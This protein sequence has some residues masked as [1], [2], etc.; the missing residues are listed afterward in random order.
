M[1]NVYCIGN[2]VTKIN[3]ASLYSAKLKWVKVVNLD[4]LN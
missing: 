3:I 4:S 1:Y 2:N